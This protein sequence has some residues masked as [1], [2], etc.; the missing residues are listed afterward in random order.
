LGLLN[1]VYES[2]FLLR[3]HSLCLKRFFNLSLQKV[4]FA[5][6][7]SFHEV[8]F[9]GPL[10]CLVEDC[11]MIG[12]LDPE[13]LIFSVVERC[14]SAIILQQISTILRQ[15][16]FQSRKTSLVTLRFWNVTQ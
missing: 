8:L 3:F 13:I 1:N 7:I 15:S 16:L 11:G 10:S 14:H 6:N 2:W 5:P 4:E 9:D 12:H